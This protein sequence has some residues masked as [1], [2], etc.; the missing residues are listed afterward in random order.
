MMNSQNWSSFSVMLGR[1]FAISFCL[2]GCSS[3]QFFFY[4]EDG[5]WR[6]SNSLLSLSEFSGKKKKKSKPFETELMNV[7]HQ[8]MTNNLINTDSCKPFKPCCVLYISGLKLLVALG[9]LKAQFRKII[10]SRL[11]H[12]EACD[13]ILLSNFLLKIAQKVWFRSQDSKFAEINY[14]TIMSVFEH[15]KSLIQLPSMDFGLCISLNSW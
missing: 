12:V 13:L 6:T 5:L 1:M 14:P 9:Y 2:T 7:H 8:K 4:R 3:I 11:V 10:K 15:P